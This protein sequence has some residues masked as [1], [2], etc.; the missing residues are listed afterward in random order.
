MCYNNFRTTNLTEVTVFISV[1]LK[2]PTYKLEDFSPHI[3]GYIS[4]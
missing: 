1:C 4:V 2:T 3:Y